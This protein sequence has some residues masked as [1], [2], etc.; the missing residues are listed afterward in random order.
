MGYRAKSMLVAVW[1][2][3]GPSIFSRVPERATDA[4]YP[5]FSLT[6]ADRSPA[7]SSDAYETGIHSM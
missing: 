6:T 4:L 1:V 3:S 7:V 2:T 5:G